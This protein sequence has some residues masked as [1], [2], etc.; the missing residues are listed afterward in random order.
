MGN[1]TFLYLG[2]YVV[3]V[4]LMSA[5]FLRKAV[6]SYREYTLANKSMGFLLTVF[7]FF[8]TWVN[9]A[10]LIGL[11]TMSFRWGISQY[12]IIAITYIMGA[13]SGPVFLTRIRKLDMYTV[14]DFFGRRFSD[15]EKIVRFL[16]ACSM[17][18]RS[19][20]I[21]GAQFTTVSFF[22]SVGFNIPFENALL[23]TAMFIV[24][25]TALSG[26]WGVAATDILQGLLQ[27]IGLSVLMYH[28]LR[29]A[30]GIS[31]IISFYDQ[32]DGTSFLNL[33]SV[34]NRTSELFFLFLAPGLFFMIEDQATWQR[35]IS[36][37][38]DKVAF[39][40]YLL[41]MGA[42]LIWVL[43]PS[44]IGVFSKSIFP[45][46]TA[47]PIALLEFILSLPTFA[48]VLIMFAILSAAV[49][50]CDSYLLAAGMIIS[51]D[52]LRNTF[53]IGKSERMSIATT[54]LG[55]VLCGGMGY[56]A[57]LQVYDIFELYMLGAYIGGAVITVPYMLAWFSK[58]MNGVGII[59]GVLT[60]FASFYIC[61]RYTDLGY[62]V[63]T[64][65]GMVI[66]LAACYL[67]CLAGKRPSPESIES[68]NYF[69]SK[70]S[71]V[72]NIP[73]V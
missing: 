18:C 32:V 41:P 64:I 25:Y 2:L 5:L 61:I 39:W 26:L 48:L 34:S 28:I 56:F 71:G 46:F 3:V 29:S 67:F 70:F 21:I 42:A 17:L 65:T 57:G 54:R 66:N 24:A 22:L 13:V 38:S 15:C 31:E 63:S 8:S 20:T 9:G 68:T 49:S 33:F 52:I 11:A 4:L 19:L 58:R 23:F 60:G 30:G 47:Y 1:I 36:A 43:V 59:A 62:S 14:G 10:T 53:H 45:S 51:Q 69:S 44:L 55:I 37:K 16:M 40:G 7:T 72:F 50:A 35:I 12:W 6:S 27:I 73:R